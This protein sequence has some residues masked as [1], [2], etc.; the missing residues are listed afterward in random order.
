[1]GERQ[2]VDCRRHRGRGAAR[3]IVP[4]GHGG[5][6]G[7]D[8]AAESGVRSAMSRRGLHLFEGYGV[9]LE[10]MIVDAET[11]NV[12]PICDELLK[13]AAGKVVDSVDMPGGVTWSNELVLHVVELKATQ[14]LARLEGA[15]A[16][17]Q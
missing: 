3:R 17:F 12:R 13:G 16:G 10:Y 11:L 5:V 2:L 1:R 6:P 7:A 8:R 15:A 4:P 14:P 9:E